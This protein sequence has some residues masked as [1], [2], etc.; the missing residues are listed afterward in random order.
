MANARKKAVGKAVGVE[1]LPPPPPREYRLHGP[2]VEPTA[3][4]WLDQPL[5]AVPNLNDVRH[6]LNGTNARLRLTP[7]LFP[8]DERLA[9]EFDYIR[10][11]EAERQAE[12]GYPLTKYATGPLRGDFIGITPLSRFVHLSKQPFGT[13]FDTVEVRQ[14]RIPNVDKQHLRLITDPVAVTEGQ[15]GA[16]MFEEETPGLYHRHALNWLL[17]A[18]PDIS[19]PRQARIW[20]ALDITIYAA[21]SAAWYFKWRDTDYRRL[22]RPSEYAKRNGLKFTVHYDTFVNPKGFDEGD[23]RLRQ[24]PGVPTGGKAWHPKSP[25]TPRHP[26]WPSGHSTYSA[27]AS[28]ILER[29]FS[30]GTIDV[31]D[32]ELFEEWPA[33]RFPKEYLLEPGWVAAQLRRLA[34]N[35][36]DGRLWAGIHWVSDHVAGQR[37]GRSTAAA[38]FDKFLGDGICEYEPP[39]PGDLPPPPDDAELQHKWTTCRAAANPNQ[40]TAPLE[41]PEVLREFVSPF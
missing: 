18:R 4:F 36:G 9:E 13:I 11:L 2:Q 3:S 37:I 24:N 5:L 41:D 28:Y 6:Y 14:Y 29:I 35:I 19:P 34:N 25:G 15:E 10:Q 27:A 16:R 20:L 8:S 17:Y 23:N 32:A 39:L 38:V 26:A 40:E 22:L 12:N 31:L 21:L 33:G 1:D 7:D 30:P